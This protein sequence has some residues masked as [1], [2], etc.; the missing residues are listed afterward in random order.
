V[1]GLYGIIL[2]IMWR[3]AL[4]ARHTAWLAVVGFVLPFVSLWI[5]T[6]KPQ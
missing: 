4:G 6:P 3:R 5:V 1:L 2:L